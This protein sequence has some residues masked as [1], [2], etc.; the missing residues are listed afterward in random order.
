MANFPQADKRNRQAKAKYARRKGQLTYIRTL[1]KRITQAI[2]DKNVSEA[3]THFNTLKKSL[4]PTVKKNLLHKNTAARWL[5]RMNR[6]IKLS[7]MASK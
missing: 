3:Q 1:K 5:S 6:C 4:G 2:S 7:A